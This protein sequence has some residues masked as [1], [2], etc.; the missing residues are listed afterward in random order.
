M[1]GIFPDLLER[2][3]VELPD[4][5]HRHSKRHWLL[6]VYPTIVSV[7]GDIC[8]LFVLFLFGFDILTRGGRR[9]NVNDPTG[10]S[11]LEDVKKVWEVRL[12]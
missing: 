4:F 5:S 7:R 11:T 6:I 8:A 10:H 9:P 2:Q 1:G 3:L 12:K